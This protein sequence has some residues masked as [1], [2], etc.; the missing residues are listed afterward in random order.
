MSNKKLVSLGIFFWFFAL[1]LAFTPSWPHLYYRIFP[2]T[3][4]TLASNLSQNPSPTPSKTPSP[5]SLPIFDPSLPLENGLIIESIGIRG[6]I[7]QGEDWQNLLKQGIWHI[8]NF[9]TPEQDQLPTI[10]AAHRWGY[11]SWTNTFRHL[12]SFYNLP[13]LK[14]GDEV[15]INW[16]QRQYHYQIYAE[17][18]SEQITDY[19]ANLILYTCQLWNSPLRI[20]KYANRI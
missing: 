14:A 8:P 9:G 18:V 7:N 13:K 12:N 10:L 1:I 6:E 11:L 20:I 5:V 2:Q 16:N 19:S 4:D 3:S 17:E 15:I